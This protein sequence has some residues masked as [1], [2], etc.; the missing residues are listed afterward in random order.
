MFLSNTLP[1]DLY[2][3][4]F[5]HASAG[6]SPPTAS[7]TIS[8]AIDNPVTLLAKITTPIFCRS[9][10]TMSALLSPLSP[11]CQ[12][13]TPSPVVCRPQP[14]PQEIVGES[15]SGGPLVLLVPLSLTLI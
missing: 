2:V 9:K 13:D 8:G 15:F 14:S 1:G 6:C 11:Q 4:Y 5:S 12:N 7:S 3:S 10:A